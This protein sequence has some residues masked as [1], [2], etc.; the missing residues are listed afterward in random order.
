MES[1]TSTS[2]D[3]MDDNVILFKTAVATAQVILYDS[4]SESDTE[5]PRQWGGSKKGKSPNIKRDFE[6]AYKMVK[7]HYFMCACQCLGMMR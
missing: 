2:G 7:R 6:G 5:A 3:D 1:D 4:D